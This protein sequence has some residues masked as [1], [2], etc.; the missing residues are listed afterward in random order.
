MVEYVI[1]RESG[2]VLHSSLVFPWAIIKGTADPNIVR[3]F[4]LFQSTDT[5]GEEAI[6]NPRMGSNPFK[7]KITFFLRRVHWPPCPAQ[8]FTIKELVRVDINSSIISI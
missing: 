4:P 5:V 8:I 1:S 7:S 6:T 2:R 3:Q